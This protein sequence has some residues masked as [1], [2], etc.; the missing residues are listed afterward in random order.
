MTDPKYFMRWLYFCFFFQLLFLFAI[1]LIFLFGMFAFCWVR[2]TTLGLVILILF[3]IL[4]VV[5]VVA[6]GLFAPKRKEFPYN[7]IWLVVLTIVFAICLGLTATYF[8]CIYFLVVILG[9]M[10]IFIL[11]FAVSWIPIGYNVART[12]FITVVGWLLC[13]VCAIIFLS[14][15]GLAQSVPW[16][17]SLLIILLIGVWVAW[18]TDMIV[19]N[20]FHKATEGDWMYGM[21]CCYTDTFI[22]VIH[23]CYMP[24]HPVEGPPKKKKVTIK[25][26]KTETKG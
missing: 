5:L 8:D 19:Q 2:Y 6:L 16:L 14:V 15:A 17:A 26:A 22:L 13:V 10:T 1:V 12:I 23:I 4:F 9:L 25:E 11:Q 24:F 7:V 20:K 3:W 21:V 18:N